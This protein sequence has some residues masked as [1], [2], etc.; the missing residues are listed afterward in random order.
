MTILLPNKQDDGYRCT[1][2][3]EGDQRT[4]GKRSC[5]EMETAGFM[6]SWKKIEVGA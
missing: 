5:T 6:Y 2:E 4:P 1:T 3:T